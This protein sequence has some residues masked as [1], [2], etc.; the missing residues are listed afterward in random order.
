LY[1]PLLRREG[2]HSHE[3][4][5]LYLRVLEFLG[6]MRAGHWPPQSFPHL[7]LGAG[8][9][10]PRFYPP[11][12]N[13]I[14]ALLT[15]ATDDVVIGVHI[16]FLLSI[17]L[18]GLAMYGYIHSVTASR[19]AGLIG[20][21]AYIGFPY[22]FQDLFV[23]GA[24]A[25]CWS[26]VWY[27]LI[28]LG[29]SRLHEGRRL[30]WYLPFAIAGL[31]LTHPLMA[32]YFA[33]VCGILILFWRPWPRPAALVRGFL[34][35]VIALGMTAWYW[36]PQRHYLPTVRA[37]QPALVWADVD[38]VNQQRVAP[39]TVLTGLPVRNAMNL[40][41]GGLA[42]GANLL[43]LGAWLSRKN[44]RPNPALL[45]R[46]TW[47]L[48]P[49]CALLLFMIVPRPWLR[50]L[51]SAFAYIQFPWRLLGPMGFLASASL[52]LVIASWNSHRL[53]VAGLWIVLASLISAGVSPNVRA[54]WTAAWLAQ[55]LA[56][57]GP[58]SGLD[59]AAEFLPLTLP[60]ARRDYAT[61][62]DGL[63]RSI[64]LGPR[65]SA[66]VSVKSYITSAS[67]TRIDVSATDSGSL[68][69]PLIY[70]DFYSARRRDGSSTAL[71][72]S[73]GMVAFTVPPGDHVV[74][75]REGL[76]PPYRL[77]FGISALSLL[78]LILALARPQSRDAVG[79]R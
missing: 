31:L 60:G 34:A 14:A 75:I 16:A 65:A 77:A 40:T 67:E 3:D 36:L 23:R 51:P 72:D 6:E 11:L 63:N 76:T 22:R 12:G 45:H 57:P 54:E 47:L 28:L 46:A 38:F 2:F 4:V 79:E 62:V 24:L 58:E 43:V 55:R 59:G 5:G 37:S 52:A 48:V 17:I 68:V 10:F 30:P 39:L 7:F 35:V 13:T 64:R 53:T 73:L 49:W 71:R 9:A 61:L 66:T 25:E 1:L 50:V 18:S 32:M 19:V 21:I 78:A 27:P 33:I 44:R 26:F 15:A 29:A 41:V 74:T 42:I 70:Y 56:P 69:L 8:Y 20:G